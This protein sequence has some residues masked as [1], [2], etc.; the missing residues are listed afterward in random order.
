[1]ESLILLFAT[2]KHCFQSGPTSFSPFSHVLYLLYQLIPEL[3]TFMG[4]GGKQPQNILIGVS[5]RQM[6]ALVRVNNPEN[7]SAKVVKALYNSAR[8]KWYLCPGFCP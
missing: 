6:K 3:K 4:V 2:S 7:V 8:G 5:E 1:M